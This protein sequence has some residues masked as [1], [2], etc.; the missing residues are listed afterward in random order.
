MKE[1]EKFDFS[2]FKINYSIENSEKK[3]IEDFYNKYFYRDS[4]L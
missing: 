4:K 1:I 2:R 3:T